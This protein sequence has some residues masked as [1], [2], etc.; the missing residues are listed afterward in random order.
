MSTVQLDEDSYALSGVILLSAPKTTVE[1]HRYLEQ[2][3]RGVENMIWKNDR[4]DVCSEIFNVKVGNE[5]HN[6]HFGTR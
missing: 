4:E 3:K 6:L 5:I 2:G 1:Q